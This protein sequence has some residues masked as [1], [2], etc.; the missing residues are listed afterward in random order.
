VTPAMRWAW[1]QT[2]GGAAEKCVLAAIAAGA[3]DAGRCG[4]SRADLAQTAEL[5][6]SGVERA[7][8]RLEGLGLIARKARAEYGDIVLVMNGGGR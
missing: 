3:D 1:G 5:S 2:A 4:V 6:R 8:Q 7:L